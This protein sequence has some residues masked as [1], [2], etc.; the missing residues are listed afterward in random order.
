MFPYKIA[1]QVS[2]LYVQLGSWRT[3]GLYDD[4]KAETGRNFGH[5][6]RWD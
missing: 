3:P 2:I 4:I 6:G 1:L 5:N